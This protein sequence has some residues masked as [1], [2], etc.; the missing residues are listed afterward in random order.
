[1]QI[2]KGNTMRTFVTGIVTG[3]LLL[4]LHLWAAPQGGQV[5][6]GQATIRQQ[7]ATTSIQQ[8]SGKAIINWQ[9]FD[10]G[11]SELVQFMQPGAQSIALN[12]VLGGDATRI[13]GQLKANGR[14][15]I[16]NPRGVLFGSG[17]S[18]DVAGL[19]ATTLDISDTDFM[20]GSFR[21][22]QV[23]GAEA[24][25]VVND[26]RIK[27]AENG[28]A[29][30]VAPTVD[31]RGLIVARLG[32]VALASGDTLTLDFKGDGLVTYAV[33]GKLVD[34]VVRNSG[35]ISNPGGEIVLSADSGPAVLSSVVNNGGI[36]EAESLVE[37]NGKV[38]LA[39]GDGA[40][41]NDGAISV[42]GAESGAA[43]GDV[44]IS[45]RFAGTDGSIEA[46]GMGAADGGR[47]VV[48]SDRH[49]LI[50]S[51]ATVDV[52]GGQTGTGGTVAVF[53]GGRSTFNGTIGARGGSE[54]GD[55]GFVD[56]SSPGTVEIF[57]QVDA[58]AAKGKTGTLLIDPKNMDVNDAGGA[59]YANGANNQF[60]NDPDGAVSNPTVITAASINGQLADVVLQANT[61]VTVTSAINIANAGTGLAIQAGRSVLVNADVTTNNGAIAITANDPNAQAANRDAG[62]AEITMAGGTSVNAGAADIA[63]SISAN[64]HGDAG[65]ITAQNVTSGGNVILDSAGAINT[66]ANFATG[67]ASVSLTADSDVTANADLNAGAVTVAAGRAATFNGSITST[68]QVS[69]VANDSNA[70]AGGAGGDAGITMAAGTILD[71]NAATVQLTVD[72]TGHNTPGGVS[73]DRVTTDGSLTI[74]SYGAITEADADDDVDLRAGILTLATA[75]PAGAM[76]GAP[77]TDATDPIEIH[78]GTRLDM[79][80]VGG[81]AAVHRPGWDT[82]D[83]FGP[84][85]VDDPLTTEIDESKIVDFG[86]GTVNLG[87][88]TLILTVTDGSLLDASPAP[89]TP[90]VTATGANL[91][92][93][94]G[95]DVVV[96]GT[97]LGSDGKRGG[98][99]GTELAPIRTALDILSASSTNSSIFINE[100]DEIVLSTVEAKQE[101][102][103]AKLGGSG[104]IVTN[105]RGV[106]LTGANNVN[107][108]AGGSIGVDV[109]TATNRA[110]LTSGDTIYDTNQELTNLTAREVILAGPGGVGQ[111]PADEGL[112]L[113]IST[114]KLT[115]N[116]ANG[117]AFLNSRLPGTFEAV[118][119][120]S[121]GGNDVWLANSQGVLKLGEVIANGGGD[122]TVNGGSGSI[123]DGNGAAVNITGNNATITCSNDVGTELLPIETTVASLSVEIIEKD[124]PFHIV[125]TDALDMISVKTND[126]DANLTFAGGTFEFDGDTS[127]FSATGVPTVSMENTGGDI[128]VGTVNAPTSVTITASGA[129]TDSG[130]SVTA[131]TATFSGGT[132]IGAAGSEINT[133]VDTLVAETRA[134]GVFIRENDGV[135]ATAVATG[136]GGDVDLATANNGDITVVK[137]SADDELTLAAA[138]SVVADAQTGPVRGDSATITAGAAIG[139]SADPLA[140]KVQTRSAT[141]SAGG[142]F[143]ENTGDL[144]LMIATATGADLSLRTT[145][146]MTLHTLAAAGQTA[147]VHSDGAITDGNAA[148]LN[149]QADTLL[150]SSGSSIGAAGAG[151]AVDIDVGTLTVPTTYGGVYINSMGAT[152]LNLVSV[153]AVGADADVEITAV[154]DIALGLVT[155]KGDDVVIVSGDE[156]TDANGDDLNVV[157]DF[158]DITGP[159][160]I[161]V[162]ETLETK[163]NSFS[164]S[165]EVVIANAGPIALTEQALEGGSSSVIADT[166]TILDIPDDQADLVNGVSLN[167][168]TPAGHIVF[169]DTNDTIVASGA[170]EVSFDAGSATPGSGAVAIIGNIETADADISVKADRHISI[171]LLDAGTGDVSVLSTA[172]VIV[173]GN[174]AANNIIARN[175]ELRGTTPT[176]RQAELHTTNSIADA[177]AHDSEAD[178]KKSLL[179]SN[180]AS[181]VVLEQAEQTQ[182]VMRD[183]KQ[184]EV[185]EITAEVDALAARVAPLEKSIEVMER[186]VQ[187]MTVA[188]DVLNLAGSIAQ[189][190]PQT[191]DGGLL[192]T[193]AAF[194]TGIGVVETSLFYAGIAY[195]I[196]A[197]D[198]E[199][200]QGTQAELTAQLYTHTQLTDYSVEVSRS[201]DEAVSISQAAYN[202]AV[203][204]RDKAWQVSRQAVTAED[205]NNA[206]GTG[207]Q[208][209][210]AQLSGAV[211]GA[212]GNSDIFMEFVGPAGVG[213]LTATNPGSTA[214]ILLTGDGNISV[215]G[216]IAADTLVRIETTGGTIANGG[217]SVSGTQFLGVA[218]A[219]MGTP[220]RLQAS[221]DTFAATAGTG[222]VGLTNDKALVIGTVDGVSGVTGAGAVDIAATSD[223]GSITVTDA[224]SGGG[225]ALTG[226]GLTQTGSITSTG[227]VRI[228]TVSAAASPVDGIQ[229]GD[230]QAGGQSVVVSATGTATAAITDNNGANRNILGAEAALTG[231]AG[232]GTAADALET[233]VGALA[234]NGGT[235]GVTVDNTGNLNLQTV[236]AV[237]TLSATGGAIAVT[238]T[239][240]LAIS[241]A[242][243]QGAGLQ[244]NLTAT[245]GSITETNPGAAADIVGD[246]VN[247]VATGPATSVGT[248]AQ[249]LELD[250]VSLNI[251]T[252]GGD[253]RVEDTAGGVTLGQL[254]TGGA[255]GS[256]LD[257]LATG[258]SIVAATPNDGVAELL[259]ENINL[260]VT[261]G[262]SV[263]GGDGA[264]LELD[265]TT[266]NALSGGGDIFLTDLAGGV[267]IDGVSTTGVANSVIKLRAVGGSVTESGADGAA[268]ISTDILHLNVTGAGSTIGRPGSALETQVGTLRDVTTEGGSI[269]LNDLA[270]GVLV[271]HVSTTG[272]AGSALD[273]TVTG[274]SILESQPDA[275]ADLISDVMLLTVTGAASTIGTA[276]QPLEI[277]GGTLSAAT[278]GGSM[279]L[280]D[281]AD[282]IIIDLLTT[283]GVQDS[284]IS[285]T[286]LEGS[287]L[288]TEPGD[289]AVDI[290]T[291]LLD[292]MVTGTGNFIGAPTNPIEIR[293]VGLEATGGLRNSLSDPHREL[294]FVSAPRP[295]GDLIIVDGQ[296]LGGGRIRSYS[297]AL[298][299]LRPYELIERFLSAT[300][301]PQVTGELILGPEILVTE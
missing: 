217:G 170:G 101:G 56:V 292:L 84:A 123:T 2:M 12:R 52:S 139:T 228:T 161:A 147:T 195:E 150:L 271:E 22:K 18:V 186:S 200:L 73:I 219:G 214:R 82:L 132:G 10:I 53:S 268:D 264:S 300:P 157:A 243:V 277:A 275:D 136:T 116:S 78:V 16:V 47:V 257:L 103:A 202:A 206:I 100:A 141:A 41:W 146:A 102:R 267:A 75:D 79:T 158:L 208:N 212:A 46:V 42:S 288:E 120:T 192:G 199:E 261:G 299:V 19:L 207:N 270:G 173:D 156:I 81:Y 27:A 8:I 13:L 256:V 106:A 65:D 49:S 218:T 91:V 72:P 127:D 196:L 279:Y 166:I 280:V 245:G 249:P 9:G 242:F 179:E 167:L 54:A 77:G 169:L 282:G 37:R 29:F 198:L 188:A 248:A 290:W 272:A 137:V 110:A 133:D 121:G 286:A 269:Y 154:D 144:T 32:T 295:P 233:E 38:V 6:A 44:E 140:T 48:S 176:A 240:N 95:D 99:I 74:A 20:D 289:P 64:G 255:V 111:E 216:G 194:E 80:T 134:G 273:L 254:T 58:T 260:Q 246:A 104:V 262:A 152:P 251:A 145:G 122:V 296:V 294:R 61:D 60:A 131:A 62:A 55:G 281:V 39:G 89:G 172:G 231:T 229:L 87:D 14:V 33:S 26:G 3:F 234:A 250:A 142:L 30:L 115:A 227:P 24:S 160:G 135:T 155:A 301:E 238:T 266:L 180:E 129:I 178:A 97:V 210:G 105:L 70:P 96:A 237:T 108:T 117:G 224:I 225:V 189:A 211:T 130:S 76:I 143:V 15:F 298:A 258:G 213:D 153:E 163:I 287:I 21:F 1:M 252:G 149:I 92:T 244:V 4:P 293:A 23:E 71:A 221:V 125:E 86:L 182:I 164:S 190:I 184:V 63:L 235:G 51:S 205:Q 291:H 57:G 5:V 197:E 209:F 66:G 259:A 93:E 28:F 204:A 191:G 7:A 17:S 174:G 124:K 220:G 274:G 67:A 222:G 98:T 69:V 171:G 31:N 183:A 187:A 45:G 128:A 107:V 215:D 118:Q 276:A 35:S 263:M 85:P 232:V 88:A 185:D 11:A 113:D 25:F 230:I 148:A 34:Q 201:A 59:A 181:A 223:G 168:S 297:Q 203:I 90:N 126:G 226:S 36:I 151:N 94:G 241:N 40:V 112:A 265:A 175:L 236:D 119:V 284:T 114:N 165:G 247:L 50:T 193:A 83:F 239:G 138:G 159:G 109:V 285:L 278:A 162:G 68:G 43:G 283:L 253:I 177:H